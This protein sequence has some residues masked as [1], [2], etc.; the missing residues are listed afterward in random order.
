[1]ASANYQV[2]AA[3]IADFQRD[4]AVCIRGAF[5]GWVDTI[6][7]GIDRNM[8]DRSATASDIVRDG[9][10]SFF[11]DYC[12]WERIP[13]FSRVVRESP[14]AAIAAAVMRS[15]TAQ[16]F[17]DHVLVKEPGTQ[18]ATPWHQ[19]IPYYFVDG[20]QTV[21]FWIPID[22]VK[23]AT[24]RVVAGSHKWEQMILPVR[25][26][27]DSRF[28][29]GPENYRPVPDPDNDP[30]MQVLEWEMAPGDAVLFDFRTAHGA[31]G[32]LAPSRRRVLSLRWVGD[33]AR[34]VERPGRT[35]PP[36]P[37]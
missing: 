2:H 28:Y 5:T 4:G 36:Y 31:R 10:G 27:D 1:M 20:R 17:H 35:S 16:F 34:Y 14:A 13:E 33:D 37:G 18:K 19:D 23:E 9:K 30:S 3:T 12:N 25:W 7:A 29:A 6:A 24:L 22:P 15:N 26:L 11:D 8:L 32:N 21:S